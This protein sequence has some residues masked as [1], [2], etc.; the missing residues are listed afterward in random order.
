[1][2]CV[3]EAG[4]GGESGGLDRMQSGR[5]LIKFLPPLLEYINPAHILTPSLPII[6][7]S[8]P[9]C[10]PTL[11]GPSFLP[12]QSVS[13]PSFSFHLSFLILSLL[14]SQTLRAESG[15]RE[16]RREGEHCVGKP[17]G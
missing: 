8:A 15:D 3:G 9:P 2:G 17:M 10:I 5:I 14:A 4:G 13:L 6:L 7:P 12:P 16:I 1:M 11:R